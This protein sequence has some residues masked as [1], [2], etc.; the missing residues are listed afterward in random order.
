MPKLPE[1][2]AVWMGHIHGPEHMKERYAVDNVYY[3]EDIAAKLTELKP[4]ALHVLS[5]INSDR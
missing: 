3:S 5:G 4:P 2:Y 1:A